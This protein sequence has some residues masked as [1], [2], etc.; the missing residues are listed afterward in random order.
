MCSFVS[1]TTDPSGKIQWQRVDHD[2]LESEGKPGPT[3]A[4]DG[5]YFAIVNIGDEPL[6]QDVKA[7]MVRHIF[8]LYEILLS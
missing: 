4:I 1:S 2:I 7:M 5:R 8:D 3:S 6:E